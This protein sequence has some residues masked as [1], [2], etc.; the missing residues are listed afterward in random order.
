MKKFIKIIAMLAIVLSTL[1]TCVLAEVAVGYIEPFLG[2]LDVNMAP[3][4]KFVSKGIAML[5]LVLQV[6]QYVVPIIL[7]ITMLILNK[8]KNNVKM[9]LIYLIM[10]IVF[11]F[12]IVGTGF[13]LEGTSS[14]YGYSSMSAGYI[15][16][17]GK[18]IYYHK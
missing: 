4:V 5:L 8:G 16:Y 13:I 9:V 12:A 3:T 2:P 11:G 7:F 1:T 18:I 14:S 6:L 10:S 15:N 17:N